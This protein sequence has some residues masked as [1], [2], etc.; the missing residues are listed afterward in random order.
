VI[1]LA[2]HMFVRIGLLAR[3]GRFD[4]PLL[5]AGVATMV[6]VVYLLVISNRRVTATR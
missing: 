2:S 6:A 4:T 1:F 5:V 3:R